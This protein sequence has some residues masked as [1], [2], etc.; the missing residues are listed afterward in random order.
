MTGIAGAIGCAV[1]RISLAA[2]PLVFP[3]ASSN[4]R[5]SVLYKGS[6]IGYHKVSYSSEFGETRVTTEINLSVK[7]LLLTL[8]AFRHSSQEIWRDGRLVSLTSETLEKGETLHVNGVATPEGFRI[9]SNGGPFIANAA[10]MTTNNL[11]TPAVLEQETVVDAHHGGIIG[12]SARKFSDEQ[13]VI[14]GR[15]IPATRY[16]LITPHLAGSIWYDAQNRWVGGEFDRNGKL[17]Q[18]RL[19]T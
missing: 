16:T 18:Y 1:P 11:W 8:F 9:E 4:L 7:L 15:R 2:A 5:F 6:R 3:T 17:I 14:A 10:T 13:I 12:V 19:E